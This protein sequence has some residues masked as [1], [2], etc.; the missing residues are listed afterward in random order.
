[1]IVVS[2]RPV[3]NRWHIPVWVLTD[4][5]THHGSVR[6]LKGKWETHI[7]TSHMISTSAS[8]ASVASTSHVNAFASHASA[9]STSHTIT[10]S[11]QLLTTTT[12]ACHD[13][14]CTLPHIRCCNR[15]FSHR[16]LPVTSACH[17]LTAHRHVLGKSL[18][19]F[20]LPPPLPLPL[21]PSFFLPP[22]SLTL[23]PFFF[24]FETLVLTEL[25][26]YCV[27]IHWYKSVHTSLTNHQVESGTPFDKP[28]SSITIASTSFTI[29]K[30]KKLPP[31]H[32]RT[33]IEKNMLSSKT[34]LT[35]PF[36]K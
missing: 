6:H 3:W 14:C 30:Q 13:R 10:T 7:P 36:T 21:H 23:L 26:V 12:S 20:L 9:A 25:P 32:Q 16:R 18:L 4:M 27:S 35:W 17:N 31:T 22:P 19:L 34:Y 28:W 1:M 15:C 5:Q 2:P 8:H 29:K 24:L 11:L 33:Q